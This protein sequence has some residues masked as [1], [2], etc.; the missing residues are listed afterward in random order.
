M[1]TVLRTLRHGSIF[2]TGQS[3]WDFVLSTVLL[4]VAI[5]NGANAIAKRV[6]PR[7]ASSPL[8]FE[9]VYAACLTYI[10]RLSGPSLFVLGS[11]KLFVLGTRPVT[12]A[13]IFWAQAAFVLLQGSNSSIGYSRLVAWLV[14]GWAGS[15]LAKYHLEDI[16]LVGGLLEHFA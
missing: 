13:G 6:C 2:A 5:G 3:D 12:A 4:V 11:S 10:H 15:L 8:G 1:S 9:S 14:A 7:A 16:F